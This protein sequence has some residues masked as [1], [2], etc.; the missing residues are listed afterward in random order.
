MAADRADRAGDSVR[1]VDADR[2][3]DGAVARGAWRSAGEPGHYR[4]RHGA[5]IETGIT[6]FG[7]VRDRL[8]KLGYTLRLPMGD[9]PIHRFERGVEHVDVMVA[10]R[11]AP[12]WK[13]SVRGVPVFAVPGGTSALRKT[14]CCDMEINGVAVRLSVPDVLGALV[15][16]GAAYQEDT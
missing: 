3:V 9:G 13:P 8:E 4:R 7:G 14:V 16:K 15:L 6:T 11:L 12:K 1:S 10:D 2:W 5:A